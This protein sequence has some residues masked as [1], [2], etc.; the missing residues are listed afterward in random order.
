MK[1]LMLGDSPFVRT[2]FGVVNRVA[3]DALLAAGHELVVLGGQDY[4]ERPYEDFVFV[5]SSPGVGDVMGWGKARATVKA[6]KPDAVHIIGD[7]TMV[8]L[9]L[10]VEEIAALPLVVYMPVE[11]EP[12]NERWTGLWRKAPKAGIQFITC[13]EYGQRVFAE[14]GFDSWMAYHGVSRDFQ[15]LDPEYRAEMRRAVG[16]DDRFVV[17]CVAQNVRRK[18]WP[19]L[20]EAVELVSRRHPE[21][22]L[23][24]HTVPFNNYWLGGWDLPQVAKTIGAW[25]RVQFPSEMKTHN[26]ALALRGKDAPGLVDLYNMADLF[27]LPSQVEG[28]GLPLAEA[29]ACGLPVAHTDWAAGAEVVGDAGYLMEPNDYEWFQGGQKYANVDRFEIANTISK[30]IES[31]E[32]R[33]RYSKKGLARARDKFTWA[34]YERTLVE[35]FNG[36]NSQ[37]NG[38]EVQAPRPVAEA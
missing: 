20:I 6:H 27:V 37:V 16:W 18:Q 33:K 35:R 12:L 23:Y 8:T 21:V 17:M 32:Q 19:R 34:S 26:D 11:G 13:S 38:Q 10:L 28:F 25:D 31:P 15:Q 36:L 29:M 24:A 22:L 5:P 1:I 2:G 3:V 7:A 9:W 30:A 14:A 4:I